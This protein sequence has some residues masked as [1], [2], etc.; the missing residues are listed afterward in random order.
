MSAQPISDKPAQQTTDFNADLAKRLAQVNSTSSA[1]SSTTISELKPVHESIDSKES[2]DL[3]EAEGK[4]RGDQTETKSHY[5]QSKLHETT[6]QIGGKSTKKYTHRKAQVQIS[7]VGENG[8]CVTVETEHLRGQTISQKDLKD[9]TEYLYSQSQVMS[10]FAAGNT[11]DYAYV[12][13]RFNTLWGPRVAPTDKSLRPSPYAPITF[14]GNKN[15]PGGE[16]SFV[17]MGSVAYGDKPND[18]NVKAHTG[19]ISF[20]VRPEFQRRSGKLENVG[21]E[22]VSTLFDVADFYRKSGYPVHQ[23]TKQEGS[24]DDIEGSFHPEN[25]G[26]MKTMLFS[27][28]KV[29]L[30][31]KG[32][33]KVFMKEFEN[34]KGQKVQCPRYVMTKQFG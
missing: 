26:S 20:M 34:N 29:V 30:D 28:M 15:F 9:V 19:L 10:H 18:V 16:G 11:F 7:P 23:N 22:I 27:G 1:Q 12:E 33:P 32:E 14:R 2:K 6:L 25:V 17:G 4:R 13:K 5:D 8:I 31:D 21:Y 24:L 3:T